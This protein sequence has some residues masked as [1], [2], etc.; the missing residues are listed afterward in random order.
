M[1]G[2]VVVFDLV[3]EEI[4]LRLAHAD[5]IVRGSWLQEHGVVGDA[6]Y[7]VTV[8]V[9]PGAELASVEIGE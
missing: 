4:A 3:G 9:H 1:L 2:G 6:L 8:Y 7:S 5:D